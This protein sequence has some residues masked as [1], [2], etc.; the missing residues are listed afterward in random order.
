MSSYKCNQMKGDRL[1]KS[2]TNLSDVYSHRTDLYPA[3]LTQNCSGK[4][5]VK[6]TSCPSLRFL[7][8]VNTLYC[9]PLKAQICASRG[10]QSSVGELGSPESGQPINTL[11]IKHASQQ[12]SCCSMLANCWCSL[13][14]VV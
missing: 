3:F 13:E 6:L 12:A 9:R 7:C 5:Q 14:S 4:L 11:E 2:V 1:T 8:K 10:S